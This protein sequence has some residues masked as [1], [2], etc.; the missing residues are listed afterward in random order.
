MILES[1]FQ[2]VQILL[3]LVLIVVVLFQVK[4]AGPGATFGSETGIFRTRR[5][6]EKT[7]FQFT[8]FVGIL[9]I[10]VSLASSF[11]IARV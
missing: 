10:V 2:I 4:G 1:A 3:A 7:L 8:I 6:F 5:G 9:F 11:I